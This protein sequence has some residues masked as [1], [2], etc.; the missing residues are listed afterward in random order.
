MRLVLKEDGRIGRDDIL[1]EGVAGG[2]RVCGWE[3]RGKVG[4]ALVTGNRET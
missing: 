1:S 3:G 4:M 2:Q